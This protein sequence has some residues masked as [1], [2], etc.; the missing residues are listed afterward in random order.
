[1]HHKIR[2]TCSYC[3]VFIEGPSINTL[4]VFSREKVLHGI[5][6]NLLKHFLIKTF[7]N[8]PTSEILNQK[9]D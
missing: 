9:S 8:I 5:F 2:A 6:G 3:D 1:M 7:L 4:F